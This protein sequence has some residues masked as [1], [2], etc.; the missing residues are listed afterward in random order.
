MKNILVDTINLTYFYDYK[1]DINGFVKT[2]SKLTKKLQTMY[3][4]IIFFVLKDRDTQ[5]YTINDIELF[6]TCHNQI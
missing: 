2:I 3:G 5:P 1:V 4:G 6:I